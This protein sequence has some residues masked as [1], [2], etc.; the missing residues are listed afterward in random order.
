MQSTY[1]F[2]L[3]RIRLVHQKK[4]GDGPNGIQFGLAVDQML[5]IS[6]NLHVRNDAPQS[7]RRKIRDGYNVRRVHF[8]PGHSTVRVQLHGEIVT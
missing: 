5:K 1:R 4:S 3:V 8:T 6:G 7:I 2:A